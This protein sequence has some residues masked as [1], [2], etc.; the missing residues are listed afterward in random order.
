MERTSCIGRR[1]RTAISFARCVFPDKT[2]ELVIE[3][4]LTA[5]AS[6]INLFDRFRNTP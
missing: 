3:V 2:R 5:T 6:Q 4:N 1:T